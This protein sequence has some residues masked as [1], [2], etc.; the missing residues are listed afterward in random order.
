MSGIYNLAASALGRGKQTTKATEEDKR[1]LLGLAENKGVN[2]ESIK[3][4]LEKAV[5]PYEKDEEGISAFEYANQA[6]NLE[7]MHLMYQYFPSEAAKNLLEALTLEKIEHEFGEGNF[8]EVAKIAS[9]SEKSNIPFIREKSEKLALED[10]EKIIDLKENNI[11]IFKDFLS[12]KPLIGSDLTKDTA[13]INNALSFALDKFYTNPELLDQVVS[14]AIEQN[15]DNNKLKQDI[16][17]KLVEYSNNS[18]VTHP[19]AEKLNAIIQIIGA[20]P[21]N[22][23]FGA[24]SDDDKRHLANISLLIDSEEK[25]NIAAGNIDESELIDFHKSVQALQKTKLPS[26]I[27]G[28]MNASII[29]VTNQY[30]NKTTDV[31]SILTIADIAAKTEIYQHSVFA[32]EAKLKDSKDLID[33]HLRNKVKDI[34]GKNI[35]DGVKLVELS[36]LNRFNEFLKQNPALGDLQDPGSIGGV[37]L[38]VALTHAAAHPELLDNVVGIARKQNLERVILDSHDYNES[39]LADLGTYLI[40]IAN[41]SKDEQV[42]LAIFNSIRNHLKGSLLLDDDYQVESLIEA[43]N[44]ANNTKLVDLLLTTYPKQFQD[45]KGQIDYSGISSLYNDG[46]IDS[47]KTLLH[48]S[49]SINHYLSE[50]S[51]SY[52]LANHNLVKFIYD[53]KA[54]HEISLDENSTRLLVNSA[55]KLNDKEMLADV[56]KYVAERDNKNKMLNH[57][58]ELINNDPKKLNAFIKEIFNDDNSSKSMI[59]EAVLQSSTIHNLDKD[60]VKAMA[61]FY[62][63]SVD[64]KGEFL[65]KVLDSAYTKGISFDNMK[66]EVNFIMRGTNNLNESINLDGMEPQLKDYVNTRNSHE[67]RPIWTRVK[68]ILK[69]KS[70][71]QYKEDKIKDKTFAIKLFLSADKEDIGS[72]ETA[73]TRSNS[74]DYTPSLGPIVASV[75]I[76]EATRAKITSQEESNIAS[77]KN[78]RAKNRNRGDIVSSL[79]DEKDQEA[80]RMKKARE[81]AS[82]ATKNVKVEEGA[83]RRN[84]FPPFNKVNRSR[85]LSE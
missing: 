70:L 16:S 56:M 64:E 29:E 41:D 40:A 63:P 68:A 83:K 45:A 69:G 66:A 11:A 8:E 51:D 6:K 71:E 23:I 84:S 38:E 24:L 1:L 61:P 46:H 67:K 79:R 14:L 10:G 43:A 55:M 18:I 33:L 59:A 3:S 9:Y 35:F 42:R 82:G 47:V 62:N 22:Y 65:S 48:S 32:K 27:A 31:S 37:A 54:S 2:I 5:D 53:N 73:S 17:Q 21:E 76:D 74:I 15:K 30:L 49:E 80:I 52:N 28:R 50:A 75:D 4:L 12:R 39:S 72:V 25:V 7:A 19:Y 58:V 13:L 36:Q 60:S 85:T 34:L 81:A 78:R 77:E 57:A 20:V 26:S 44:S